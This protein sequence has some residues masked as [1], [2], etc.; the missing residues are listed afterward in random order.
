MN[1]TLVF[2]LVLCAVVAFLLYSH[3]R[4]RQSLERLEGRLQEAVT[5]GQLNDW[6]LPVVSEIQ[7]GQSALATTVSSLEAQLKHLQQEG[8]LSSVEV[9]AAREA[10]DPEELDAGASGD[11]VEEDG[12]GVENFHALFAGVAQMLGSLRPPRGSEPQVE[13]VLEAIELDEEGADGEEES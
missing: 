3:Q 2:A 12:H 6:V 13:E 7:E 10:Y 1:I 8:D 11:E 4:Q 9:A 5:L